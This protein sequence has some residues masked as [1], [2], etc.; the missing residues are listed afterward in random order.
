V[1]FNEV[2]TIKETLTDA[3]WLHM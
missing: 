2:S 3:K 1:I